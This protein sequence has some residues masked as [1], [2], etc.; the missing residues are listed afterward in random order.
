MSNETPVGKWMVRKKTPP[1]Y[2][3]S[4]GPMM[5]ACQWKRSSPTGPAE[6]DEGGSRPRSASSLLMRL[7]AIV[8][9]RVRGWILIFLFDCVKNTYSAPGQNNN[10]SH[11]L[12]LGRSFACFAR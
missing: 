8:K 5:V 3:L 2:G 7:S 6:H 11:R 9:V 1:E 12:D 10:G 4:P